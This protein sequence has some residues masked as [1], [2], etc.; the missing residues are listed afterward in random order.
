MTS[1]LLE[2]VFLSIVT[3]ICSTGNDMID[4]RTV[5]SHKKLFDSLKV[6]Q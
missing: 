3:R 1:K 6:R 5:P 4:S 2:F